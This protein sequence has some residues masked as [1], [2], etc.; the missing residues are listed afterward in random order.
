M[1]RENSTSWHSRVIPLLPRLLVLVAIGWGLYL[2]G[3]FLLQIVNEYLTQRPIDGAW[4][5]ALLLIAYVVF[6]AVPFM[7]GIEVGLV[8]MLT[9]GLE[10]VIT[11]YLATIL[12]LST[13]YLLGR[14]VPESTLANFLGWLGLRR[15]EMLV[16]EIDDMAPA[17][18]L[19]YLT[20]RVPSRWVPFLLRHRYLAIAVVLNTPG[21]AVIGGGGGIGMVA[22]ISGLFPF[23]RYLA[24]VALAVSPIPVML[25]LKQIG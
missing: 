23:T 2:G 25:I 24:L 3:D 12:A 22:G 1:N 18:R 17:E 10:G 16:R 4:L 11:V 6:M 5:L 9:G 8:V 13:S 14:L 15:A 21:N 20:R 19:L 7:P